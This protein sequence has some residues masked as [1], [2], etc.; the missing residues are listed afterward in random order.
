LAALGRSNALKQVSVI[1]PAAEYLFCKLT[2]SQATSRPS[3]PT[4]ALVNHCLTLLLL[5]LFRSGGASMGQFPKSPFPSNLVPLKT[6][7]DTDHTLHL[8]SR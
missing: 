1:S 7:L 5:K 4:K 8:T 6:P 2:K 3:K